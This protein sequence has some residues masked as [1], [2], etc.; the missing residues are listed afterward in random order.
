MADK[1]IYHF[2][3][4][5]IDFFSLYVTWESVICST[6]SSKWHFFCQLLE[7]SLARINWIRAVDKKS[8][9]QLISC[10]KC[11]AIACRAIAIRA[12][13]PHSTYLD[14]TWLID[15][16][17]FPTRTSGRGA[18]YP[19]GKL[20]LPKCEWKW[21]KINF[22]RKWNK[23]NFLNFKLWPVIFDTG[24]KKMQ[25][26]NYKQENSQNK[27]NKPTEIHIKHYFVCLV[28]NLRLSSN[29]RKRGKIIEIIFKL[30]DF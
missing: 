24:S 2:Y 10:Q 17:T 12:V 13:H 8:V 26:V 22:F 1:I 16:T 11:R 4:K 30:F 28:D 21:N 14:L 23:I 18:G 9:E 15:P 20:Q 6:L 19:S 27:T 3:R 7:S 29:S 25:E 5:K